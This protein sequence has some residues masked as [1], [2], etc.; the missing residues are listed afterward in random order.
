MTNDELQAIKDRL[1]AV[2]AGPWPLLKDRIWDIPDGVE[3]FSWP[4]GFGPDESGECFIAKSLT[5]IAG[6]I[7]ALDA[8]RARS[9][10]F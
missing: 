7:E 2:M 6:L 1:A 5:D 9:K 4:D 8:E 10:K 3:D